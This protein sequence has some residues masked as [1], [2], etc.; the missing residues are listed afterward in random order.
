MLREAT[1]TMNKVQFT[2]SFS[3]D[4]RNGKINVNKLLKERKLDGKL[5]NYFNC[6]V[7]PKTYEMSD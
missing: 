4:D 5:Q 3:E 6:L 1:Y 2:Y 7:T